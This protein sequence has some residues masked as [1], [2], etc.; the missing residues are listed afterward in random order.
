MFGPLHV[1]N[2]GLSDLGLNKN[3]CLSFLAIKIALMFLNQLFRN[4]LKSFGA[5]NHGV[6]CNLTTFCFPRKAGTSLN[7][8]FTTCGKIIFCSK[9][10]HFDK[11]HLKENHYLFSN[12]KIWL[13]RELCAEEYH[14]L[15]NKNDMVELGVRLIV[16]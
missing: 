3:L 5:L 15:N 14:E 13:Y 6:V 16:F 10:G 2:F 7:N 1:P 8:S 4:F 9:K 12:N 11:E